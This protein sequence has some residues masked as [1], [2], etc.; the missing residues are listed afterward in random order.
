MVPEPCDNVPM[1][2][3]GRPDVDATR[4]ARWLR[5]S[6]L[7]LFVVGIGGFLID[8]AN[9]PANPYLVPPNGQV[10]TTGW[11]A[12]GSA[13]LSITPG[14]GLV[15][16][17]K[18]ACALVATT[19]AEQNQGLMNQKSLHGYAGMVFEWRAPTNALFW[20]KDTPMS[21]SVAWFNSAGQYLAAFSMIPCLAQS[22]CATYSPGVPYQY[23][24]EV[25]TGRL[26]GL[27]I[28]PGSTMLVG[29]PC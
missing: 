18:R 8:G 9:R 17:K 29:G 28:G 13:Y 27:G 19:T 1:W 7:T 3:L 23:A 25:P 14:A 15:D 5:W 10:S 6:A 4:V 21:L 2:Q 20:M 24:L 16:S 12:F 11:G 26:A 22:S